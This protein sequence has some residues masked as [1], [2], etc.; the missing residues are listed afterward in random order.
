MSQIST[1]WTKIQGCYLTRLVWRNWIIFCFFLYVVIAHLLQRVIF[2]WV[3]SWLSSSSSRCWDFF[4]CKFS[5][6]A[7]YLQFR[8][9]NLTMRNHPLKHPPN[10]N[11]GHGTLPLLETDHPQR[12]GSNSTKNQGISKDLPN[13]ER[14]VGPDTTP[15]AGN[16]AA[17]LLLPHTPTNQPYG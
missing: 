13:S 4:C 3:F 5:T 16:I 7:Y 1:F 8:N 11:Q 2:Q 6:V 9:N 14:V 10:T 17:K 12:S 15:A